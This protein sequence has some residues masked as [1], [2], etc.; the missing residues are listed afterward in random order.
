MTTRR[1]K[2]DFIGVAT[3]GL[4]IAMAIAVPLGL[5]SWLGLIT[6]IRSLLTWLSLLA[7]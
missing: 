2:S 7:G 4:W 3:G 1:R 6:L 5:L